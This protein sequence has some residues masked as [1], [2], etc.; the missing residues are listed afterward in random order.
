MERLARVAMGQAR[1]LLMELHEEPPVSLERIAEYIGV[2]VRRHR[3]ARCEPD[4]FVHKTCSGWICYINSN[5][6]IPWPRVRYSLA[7]ELMHVRLVQ[8][9]AASG[10]LFLANHS[11]NASGIER[12]CNIGAAELLMPDD[13]V[14]HWWNELEAHIPSRISILAARCEVSQRALSVKL[15]HLG[16][17]QP[18]ET[19]LLRMVGT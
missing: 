3:F 8:A 13:W 11:E 7:H 6:H 15:D 17:C 1:A 18:V 2:E 10:S 4:A 14:L 19:D 12:A 5:I 9:G 16:L